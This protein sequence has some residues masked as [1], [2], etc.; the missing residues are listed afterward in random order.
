[1]C[2]LPLSISTVCV[3]MAGRPAVPV[4][5]IHQSVDQLKIASQSRTWSLGVGLKQTSG[6]ARKEVLRPGKERQRR[7]AAVRQAVGP[8]GR[9]G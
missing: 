5:S 7:Q 6:W 2:T 9:E 8:Q 3:A 4:S 1:M